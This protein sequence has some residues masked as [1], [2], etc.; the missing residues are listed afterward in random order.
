MTVDM[1][2]VL[3]VSDEGKEE[4]AGMEGWNH[5]PGPGMR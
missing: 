2:N 1:R 4:D 5:H 3:S